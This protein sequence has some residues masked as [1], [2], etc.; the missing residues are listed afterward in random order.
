[1][2]PKE[3]HPG[4]RG[5]LYRVRIQIQGGI[6]GHNKH[7]AADVLRRSFDAGLQRLAAWSNQKS[8]NSVVVRCRRKGGDD[9]R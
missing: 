6:Q 9:N 8:L 7:G 3:A 1:M 4:Y 2:D 5:G